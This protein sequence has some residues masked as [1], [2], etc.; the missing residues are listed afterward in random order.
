MNT[1]RAESDHGTSRSAAPTM[2]AMVS[3]TYGEA[4]DVLRLEQVARPEV[5]DDDVL[6][7]VH[8]AGIDQ[9][10]WHVTAGLPYPIRLAGYGLRAPKTRVRGG[11]LAGTVAE[12]GAN[13]TT[14][15]VGDSVYGFGQGTF[16][17]YTL[18]RPDKLAHKPRNLT[19][20]QAAAVP[21]SGVTALQ[22][23]R[24]GQVRAD[25]EVLVI[26]AAG[27][28]GSFAV[29]IAKALGARVTGVASTG[30]VDLV[31]SLGADDVIDYT[32]EELTGRARTYDVI[33]DI[34]GNRPLRMLRRLL[35]PHGRLV[36]TGGETD[37]RWL[38]G[39]DRQLRA[40]FLS[41]FVRQQLGT[42]VTSQ[43]APDLAA[44]TELIEAGQVTPVLDKTY[45]L[46]QAP[47][48]IRDL[49]AGR[50]RGKAVVVV[51]A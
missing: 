31:R 21:V 18:A 35:T 11:D 16:A 33:L 14:F 8:A 37:G 4:E 38:G 29:Q 22:A 49:R 12:V 24:K 46:A 50:I 42:F 6:V 15:S 30:K 23:V 19:D 41:P 40:M 17:E 25:H 5:G 36:I 10:V 20:E 47:A 26:G 39:T 51:T 32:T 45:P 1:R 27:G 9:G 3:D 2:N 48:A 13:V 43:N 34:A 44:L 7:R 28:V